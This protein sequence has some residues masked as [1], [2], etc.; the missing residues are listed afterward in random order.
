MS[1]NSGDESGAAS[2]EGAGA[3]EGQRPE[4]FGD[5]TPERRLQ[6]LQ[7]EMERLSRMMS[8][9]SLRNVSEFGR[10]DSCGEL[11]RYSKILSGVLPKFPAEAEAPVWFES[12][13]STLEAYEVPREF[14]GQLVFP[15]VAERVP[16]LST[17][18]S[19][20]T[21]HAAPL[22]SP[23]L[24]LMLCAC[25]SGFSWFLLRTFEEAQ[26]TNSAAKHVGQK[27]VES[28]VTSGFKQGPQ[29]GNRSGAKSLG[30]ELKSKP[31]SCYTCG[32]SGH[33]RWNCPAREKSQASK[34][35]GVNS[36][37]LTARV[38]VEEPAATRGDLIPVSLGCKDVNIRAVLDT[39]A[40]ITVLR[41]SAIPQQTVQ[42]RGTVNLT[43][44]FGE[45][46]QA[47][48]VIVPLAMSREGSIQA[49]VQDAVP[50]LCA[51]TDQL[52]ERTDCLLSGRAWELLNKERGCEKVEKDT[53]GV[54]DAQLGPEDE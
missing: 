30:A 26:G 33:Q 7:L 50:V 4:R 2:P 49:D 54:G 28:Q 1:H 47:K 51:L 45:R 10:R 19:C 14:W 36:G 35:P 37:S 46:V 8:Q 17:R 43:S 24:R 11:R 21:V 20:T 16:Y 12:V 15:L 42:P 3:R 39:G 31:R 29:P 52:T 40:E 34:A 38:S 9:S 13:E 44:T 27:A 41:D 22:S 53:P 18:L 23:E 5:L 25:L 48:L 6:E 32:A